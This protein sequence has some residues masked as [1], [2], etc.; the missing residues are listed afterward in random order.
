MAGPTAETSAE[1]CVTLN[2]DSNTLASKYQ[3]HIFTLVQLR[4][5]KMVQTMI[6]NCIHFGNCMDMKTHDIH[7]YSTLC[8]WPPQKCKT[9]SLNNKTKLY[10]MLFFFFLPFLSRKRGAAL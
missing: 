3:V 10:N 6:K 7:S 1:S 2:L 4:H 8:Q 5:L 9:Q